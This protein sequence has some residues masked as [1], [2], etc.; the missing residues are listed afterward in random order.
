MDDGIVLMIFVFLA[1]ICRYLQ[2]CVKVKS[3]KVDKIGN[4][5]ESSMSIFNF[6]TYRFNLFIIFFSLVMFLLKIA[7]NYNNNDE[8]IISKLENRY[9]VALSVV[10]TLAFFD[11]INNNLG[12]NQKLNISDEMS[13]KEK[14]EI[15]RD[16]I[17]SFIIF[18]IGFVIYII[19][20]FFDLDTYIFWMSIGFSILLSAIA[21]LLRNLIYFSLFNIKKGY[22][23][24]LLKEYHHCRLNEQNIFDDDAEKLFN[25]ICM[26]LKK[27]TSFRKFKKFWINSGRVEY[28][29]DY[30]VN[31][32]SIKLRFKSALFATL[33][34]SIF[35]FCVISIFDN[36]GYSINRYEFRV[37]VFCVL[38]LY[39]IW[40]LLD[41]AAIYFTY[42]NESLFIMMENTNDVLSS[43]IFTDY[44]KKRNIVL[45]FKAL[46]N[47]FNNYNIGDDII[48]SLIYQNLNNLEKYIVLY[49]MGC[50]KSL[51][52]KID[53]YLTLDYT[54]KEKALRLCEVLNKIKV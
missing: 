11:V 6:L 3:E 22:R 25:E 21:I 33:H 38:L 5:L 49:C 35:V 23:K 12:R 29:A 44:Y 8:V 20:G 34:L 7:V 42:R 37:L 24:R 1:I 36:M 9:G 17:F 4:K 53:D 19:F 28:L 52:K 13:I 40:S 31:D 32:F 43:T 27:S 30:E 15:N 47:F 26:R 48:N 16:Y 45:Q 46:R 51:K 39:F 50:E 18:T 41:D 54:E 2:K 14:Y 10:L